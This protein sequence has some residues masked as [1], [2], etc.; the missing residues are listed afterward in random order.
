MS[1]CV[2]GLLGSGESVTAAGI[3]TQVRASRL[4]SSSFHG[5]D[6][7]SEV[8]DRPE[9]PKGVTLGLSTVAVYGPVL[10][11]LGAGIGD[12]VHM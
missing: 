5:F 6:Q 10:G 12:A 7:L 3:S 8:A 4:E 2:V 9:M 11:L 1:I